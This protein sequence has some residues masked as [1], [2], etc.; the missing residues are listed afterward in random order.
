MDKKCF[1]TKTSLSA[2]TDFRQS[3]TYFGANFTSVNLIEVKFQT[4]VSNVNS[5]CPQ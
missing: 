2:F 4:V 1:L 5:K 3:E